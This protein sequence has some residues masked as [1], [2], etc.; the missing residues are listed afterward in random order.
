MYVHAYMRAW[1]G[2]E[3]VSQLNHA[4]SIEIEASGKQTFFL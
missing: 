4:P 1:G 3:G 2:D